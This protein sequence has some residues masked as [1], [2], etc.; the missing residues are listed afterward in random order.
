MRVLLAVPTYGPN[1]PEA[2]KAIRRSVMFAAN[3]GI[4]WVDDV[5]PD[6]E[7]WRVGRNHVLSDALYYDVDGVLWCDDDML[8]EPRTFYMLLDNARERQA[9]IMSALCFSRRPPYTACAWTEDPF[10]PLT[11]YAAGITMVDGVGF[12]C[13][14]TSKLVLKTVGGFNHPQDIDED[15]YFCQQARKCG[16]P[17]WVDTHQRAGHLGGHVIIDEKIALMEQGRYSASP[18][19]PPDKDPR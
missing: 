3:N 4:T 9:N 1:Y 6:R 7:S 12:G 11:N 17:S 14:Y 5:S 15:R 16:F 19:L 13:V 10:T 8:P 18:T 2:Q